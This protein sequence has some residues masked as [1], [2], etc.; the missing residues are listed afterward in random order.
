MIAATSIVSANNYI[1]SIYN[2]TFH[3]FQVRLA[4]LAYILEAGLA[5]GLGVH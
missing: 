2:T 5:N 1:C 3:V 4:T